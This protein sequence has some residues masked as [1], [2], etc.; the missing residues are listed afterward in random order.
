MSTRAEQDTTSTIG[1]TAGPTSGPDDP[2]MIERLRA[3]DPAA[4]EDLVRTLSGRLLAV[5]RRVSRTEA[6][7]EDAVQEAF[8]LAYKAIGTFDGRSS[9][10]TWLHRIVVNAALARL[11]RERAHPT[12]SIDALLPT[13]ENGDHVEHPGRWK[14]VTVDGDRRIEQR[15][16]LLRA[17]GELPEEFREVIVLRDM[18]DRTSAQVAQAL[19]ISDALVRQRLHRAR[20]ALV[21]L[22]GPTMNAEAP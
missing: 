6:D 17:L 12:A 9:V 16:A 8:L 7:A 10:S 5:A 15:E 19:N 18:E 21:K 20:Q 1:P 3:R 22:L 13:F 4:F 11:R 2:A 14:S